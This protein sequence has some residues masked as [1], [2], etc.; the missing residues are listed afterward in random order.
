MESKIM[1]TE[2]IFIYECGDEISQKSLFNCEEKLIESGISSEHYSFTEKRIFFE[3]DDIWAIEG[4]KQMGGVGPFFFDLNFSIRKF[5]SFKESQIILD[6]IEYSNNEIRPFAIWYG[7][8]E[9]FKF[10]KFDGSLTWI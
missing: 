5:H 7:N 1:A 10:N 8:D 4:I 9:D 2:I 3:S 6:F